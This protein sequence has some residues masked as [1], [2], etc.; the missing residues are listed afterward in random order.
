MKYLNSWKQWRNG[1]YDLLFEV[2]EKDIENFETL[3]WTDLKAMLTGKLTREEW[4]KKVD[5]LHEWC[6]KAFNEVAR[7][8]RVY[9]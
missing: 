1:K 6:K 8:W 2:T 5:E 7:I 3:A 4:I 9:K